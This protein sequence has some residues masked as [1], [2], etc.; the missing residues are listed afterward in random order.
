MRSIATNVARSVVYA[1]VCV[2]VSCV[3]G[4]RVSCAKA[5]KRIEMPF[6]GQTH[7]G[8]R[9][10]VGAQIPPGR[11]TFG[12]ICR[13]IVASLIVGALRPPRANMPGQQR[14][15]AFTVAI[16]VTRQDGDAASCQITLTLVIISISIISASPSVR[17]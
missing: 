9:N 14:P 2:S 5:D 1:P 17:A 11:G 16:E 7:V 12:D 4:K 6:F 15:N 8:P 3:L 10:H 13:R